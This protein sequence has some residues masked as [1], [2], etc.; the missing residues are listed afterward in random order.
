M[1]D[2]TAIPAIATP[3]GW[4]GILDEGEQILWQGQPAQGIRFETLDLR[5][6]LPAIFII[7][8]GVF[9]IS[10]AVQFS[11]FFA[12][13]GL[14]VVGSS[15]WQA[16]GPVLRPAFIRA[17]SFYT[18]TDRRAIIATDMPFQGRRLASYPIDRTMPLEYVASDP[19]SILFGPPTSRKETRAGF[20]YIADA[21]RVMA[22]MRKIQHSQ[23]P[24][25]T[26]PKDAQP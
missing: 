5:H 24:D 7:G 18:L 23:T 26:A 16:L 3:P 13:F 9:W 20:S 10:T 8:F 1:S 14:F 25:Q 4:Q 19:P 15:L 17:R 12:A 22:M 2:A 11:L 21:D 6:I